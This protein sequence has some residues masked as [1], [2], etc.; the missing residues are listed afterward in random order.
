VVVATALR[1]VEKRQ[2][3]TLVSETRINSDKIQRRRARA[4]LLLMRNL[5]NWKEKKKS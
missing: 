4:S 1:V 5:K 2:N 3:E